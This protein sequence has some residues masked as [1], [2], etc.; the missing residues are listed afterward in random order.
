MQFFKTVPTKNFFP[1]WAAPIFEQQ[2]FYIFVR[3]DYYFVLKSSILSIYL[4]QIL[5]KTIFLLII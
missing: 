2:G 4:N 1:D 3:L 5:L